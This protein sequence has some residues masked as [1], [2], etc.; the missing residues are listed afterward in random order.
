MLFGYGIF[1]A[2]EVDCV[3][4][5]VFKEGEFGLD[6][7]VKICVFVEVVGGDVGE[8]ANVGTAAEIN[9][10]LAVGDFD[11]NEVAWGNCVDLLEQ[12]LVVA[13]VTGEV[14]FAGAVF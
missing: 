14:D 9:L 8:D 4:S 13:V 5:A 2:N 10:E 6:V 11:N 3:W 12:L 7:L 1:L